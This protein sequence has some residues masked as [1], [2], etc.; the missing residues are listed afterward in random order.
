VGETSLSRR[1]AHESPS[2]HPRRE[3]RGPSRRA[4][5]DGGHGY[6]SVAFELHSRI[7]LGTGLERDF[8]SVASAVTRSPLLLRL[9]QGSEQEPGPR[10]EGS[11]ACPSF[12]NGEVSIDLPADAG[13]ECVPGSGEDQE[14]G[15]LRVASQDCCKYGSGAV[16]A[17]A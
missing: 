15:Q 3:R 4:G 12:V 1:A 7:L 10:P 6:R 16:R 17:T 2:G 13:G 11:P 8:P 5:W 9:A 14:R